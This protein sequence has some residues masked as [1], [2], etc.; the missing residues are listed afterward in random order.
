MSCCEVSGPTDA[1]PRTRRPSAFTLVELLVVIGIIALLISILLPSLNR[2]REQANRIKCA[3]NLRQ[4][5]MTAIMYANTNRGRFPRT[6]HNPA[7]APTYTLQGGRTNSPTE[8]PFN[9]ANP[10]APVG[11]NNPAAAL[12]LIARTGDLPPA[13]FLCPSLSLSEPFTPEDTRF[14]NFPGPVRQY[15]SYSYNIPFPFQR[16][17]DR[18]WKFDTTLSPD[19]PLAADMN[20]GNVGDVMTDGTPTTQNVTEVAY[21]DPPT[22]MR[23][24]NSNNHKAVGQQVSYVDAHVEWHTSPFAG[25]QPPDRVWR[26]NIYANQNGVNAATGKGG[27]SAG[28]PWD[29]FDASMGPSDATD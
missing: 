26:D 3:S 7:V 21:N 27:G 28:R 2:A 19:F 25:P 13:S 14:A 16:A 9:L 5:A 29:R 1:R 23:R 11:P 4:I 12:F 6:Y 8:N 24:G 15:C 20:P 17:M 18:G 10:T 22:V